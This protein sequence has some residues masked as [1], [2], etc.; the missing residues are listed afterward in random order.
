MV[1]LAVDGLTNRDIGEKL[2][3]SARTV[4]SDLT[5]VYM[6]LGVKNRMQLSAVAGR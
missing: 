4:E 2:F 5:K 1:K 3:I 6:K